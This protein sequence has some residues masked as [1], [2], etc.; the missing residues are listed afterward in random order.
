[1]RRPG[2]ETRREASDHGSDMIRKRTDQACKRTYST[3]VHIPEGPSALGYSRSLQEEVNLVR[4]EFDEEFYL[5]QYE[6]VRVSGLDPLL[7]Y[8]QHGEGE[9]R[10]PRPDFDPVATAKA[11]GD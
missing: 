6:D 8:L 10:K 5:S 2:A 7:H 11:L 3:P 1:M 4:P 9:G